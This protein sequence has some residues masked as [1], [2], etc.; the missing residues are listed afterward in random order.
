MNSNNMDKLFEELLNESASLTVKELAK[1]LDNEEPA[2]FSQE[3]Q[4]RMKKLFAREKRKARMRKLGTYATRTAAV[5]AVLAV[6]SFAAIFSVG[7]LRVRFLN[8]FTNKQQT[9]TEI[10]F[11]DGSSYSN[12]IVTLGYVPEGFELESEKVM[13]NM[14]YLKFRKE[15]EYFTV[16]IRETFNDISVDTEEA[17]FEKIELNGSEMFYSEK[18]NVKTLTYCINESTIYIISNLK[19]EEM[20]KIQQNIQLN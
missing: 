2:E 7:A 6:I 12:D 8:M 16:D 17:G 14:S 13:K 15:E 9:N 20:I 1:E 10:A 18:E 19:K 11:S 3:H 5:L 4:H